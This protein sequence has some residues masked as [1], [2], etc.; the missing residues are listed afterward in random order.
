MNPNNVAY[1]Y[2]LI[3]PHLRGVKI[4]KATDPKA[5]LEAFQTGCPVRGYS[6]PFRLLTSHAFKAETAAHKLLKAHRLEGEWFDIDLALARDVITHVCA[7]QAGCL[8]LPEVIARFA[9]KDDLAYLLCRNQ[10]WFVRLPVP[11]P[12][13]PMVGANELVKTTKC[14][15]LVEAN[16]VKPEILSELRQ[17]LARAAVGAPPVD[18]RQ[19]LG[20]PWAASVCHTRVSQP[21]VTLWCT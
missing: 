1:V 3:N 20:S 2:A 12:L 4:G 17:R 6:M 14:R 9:P 21:E 19:T 5:R 13:R 7:V 18:L 16:K 10:T 8:G 11:R 15:D